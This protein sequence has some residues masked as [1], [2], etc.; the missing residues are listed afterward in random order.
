MAMS[1]SLSL[2]QP[3]L[4]S[5]A[6]IAPVGTMGQQPR[7]LSSDASATP[8]V[9]ATQQAPLRFGIEPGTLPE[10]SEAVRRVLSMSNASNAEVTQARVR[11]AVDAFAT[12]AGDTGSTPVQGEL[13]MCMCVCVCMG[14]GEWWWRACADGSGGWW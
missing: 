2:L 10:V 4:P 1:S 13:C 12:R 5:T 11:R 6:A 3:Y 9:P 14:R 8:S 7:W